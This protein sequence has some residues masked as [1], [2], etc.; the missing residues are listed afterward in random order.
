M[1]T[2]ATPGRYVVLRRPVLALS[3]HPWQLFL[4]ASPPLS[5]S[6]IAFL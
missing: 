2:S 5:L 3:V 6:E 1:A 4:S